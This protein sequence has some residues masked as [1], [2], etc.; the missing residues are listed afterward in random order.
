M[1]AQYCIALS[2]EATWQKQTRSTGIFTLDLMALGKFASDVE[3]SFE[4][5]IG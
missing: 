2:T 1:S 3:P 4:P 5:P